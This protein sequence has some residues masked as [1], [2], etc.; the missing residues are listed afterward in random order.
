LSERQ[1]ATEP[2]SRPFLADIHTLRERARQH[3]SN[4]AVTAPRVAHQ[5]ASARPRS[6]AKPRASLAQ[7]LAASMRFD[8]F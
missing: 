6:T 4:G 3:L 1:V 2:R 7:R 8:T 5:E